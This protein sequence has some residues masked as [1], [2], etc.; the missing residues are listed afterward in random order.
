MDDRDLRDRFREEFDDERPTPDDYRSVVNRAFD[1]E[2]SRLPGWAGPVAALLAV[3]M[4]TT[5]A[6]GPRIP[7]A[8]QA[9]PAA[10]ARAD[11]VGI[12]TGARA[13]PA[14]PTGL[15]EAPAVHVAARNP[16]EALVSAGD[17]I[18]RTEDGGASWT[19]LFA[20]MDGHRGTVRDLE[21]VTGTLAFAATSYGLLR[22]DTRPP[23]FSLVNQRTDFRRLD[24]L[25]PLEGYAI[26]EDRVL[27]TADGGR[28][29]ADLDVGLT[30]VSWI[31]WVSAGQAWAAGPRGVVATIDG[32]RTWRQQLEFKDSPETAGSLPWTQ[33]GFVDGLSGFAYHHAD[34]TN[35][36]LH[37]SDG[38]RSWEPAAEVP[39]GATSD[40]VVTGPESA[41]LVQHSAPGRPSLCAT[42]DA[43]MS[44][45]C[46]V[47]PLPGD[48]GQ[49]VV[50]GAARWL[51]LFDSGA[52]FAVSQNG[53][54]WSTRRRAFQ[55]VPGL[56]EAA[57]QR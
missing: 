52:V 53:Q 11:L 23:G 49:M 9:H 55:A 26:A 30:L 14:A 8:Q 7:H 46:S 35:T 21:W 34:D 41:E 39:V 20:G 57:P 1:Q 25:T 4:V 43:G 44:W 3:T 15:G 38:G 28:T 54:T 51:A 40:L 47:L 37:T 17:V 5:L 50:K 31:Q 13:T 33:V 18:E 32:G 2:S 24:F 10:A 16:R 22:L 56:P 12:Q 29:F 36:L 48:P 42:V 27:K 45:R 6:L 19:V